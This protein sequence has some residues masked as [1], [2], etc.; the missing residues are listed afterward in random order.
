MAEGKGMAHSLGVE[1]R[2]Q[3][4]SFTQIVNSFGVAGGGLVDGNYGRI[5]ISS[6]Y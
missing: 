1:V 6:L 4:S 3:K 2:L 5:K